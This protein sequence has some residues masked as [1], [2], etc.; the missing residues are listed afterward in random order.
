VKPIVALGGL[1][2]LAFTTVQAANERA[3]ATSLRRAAQ[4]QQTAESKK[5]DRITELEKKLHGTWYGPDCGGD[6]AF[7]ADGAFQLKNFTPGQNTLSGTWSIRWDALPP[8]L[9]ILCK[10]ADFEGYE[11]L[12][13]PLEVKLLELKS[14]SLALLL[15]NNRIFRYSRDKAG[16][17]SESAK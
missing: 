4:S 11:L 9:V 14:D 6:Y 1:F 8:T 2:A 16:G 17:S 12:N 13:K 10:T 15:P 7:A 5:A 3:P